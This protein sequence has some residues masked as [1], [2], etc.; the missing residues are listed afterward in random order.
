MVSL[1]TET[2]IQLDTLKSNMLATLVFLQ[3]IQFILLLVPI[4]ITAYITFILVFLN[5]INSTEKHPVGGI[6]KR[7]SIST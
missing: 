7:S 1:I 6:K 5:Y 2:V 3:V 4:S